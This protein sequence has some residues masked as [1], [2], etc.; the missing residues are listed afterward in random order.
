MRLIIAG[1]R[2]ITDIEHVQQVMRFAVS[3]GCCLI[4]VVSGCAPGVDQL[5]EQWAA[6]NGIPVRQFPADWARYPRRAGR[7]RNAEMANYADALVAIWD[8]AS[9][10]TRHMV[11]TMQALGK[12]VY[13]H[14]VAA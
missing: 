1:S 8:G 3:A 12:P 14:K 9:S 4:E 13:I 6:Q 11:Q 10:G 5:G 2:S 7:M